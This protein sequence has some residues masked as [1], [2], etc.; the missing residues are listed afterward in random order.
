MTTL[1]RECER[2]QQSVMSADTGAEK[3]DPTHARMCATCAEFLRRYESFEGK[4][5]AEF[6]PSDYQP[7]PL[8]KNPW[9]SPSPAS[10]EESG[11]SWWDTWLA[12]LTPPRLAVAMAAVLGVLVLLPVWWRRGP[13][14][15]SGAETSYLAE[16]ETAMLA[17]LESGTGTVTWQGRPL[18]PGSAKGIPLGDP[19]RI[20]GEAVLT[21]PKG[22]RVTGSDAELRLCRAGV[23]LARGRLE[24]S[25]TPTPSPFRVR[26][27]TAEISVLGTMFTVTVA[28]DGTTAVAVASGKVRVAP[29]TGAEGE[30][31][32]APGESFVVAGQA[33][34]TPATATPPVPVTSGLPASPP[35]GASLAPVLS[36][37]TPAITATPAFTATPS[38]LTTATA[39]QVGSPAPAAVASD[40][41]P[42]EPTTLSSPLDDLNKPSSH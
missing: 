25:V 14:P 15:G 42:L 12:F 35:S 2:F 3:P 6:D 32:L 37:A 19:L 8:A 11:P 24:V 5:K 7:L 30:R 21:L 38:A 16:H 39:A 13:L 41:V 31:A 27:P 23:E 33:G 28:N 22:V 20:A 26:T 18:E 40:V 10:R 34:S 9:E 17:A 4:L 36:P 1:S 29:L